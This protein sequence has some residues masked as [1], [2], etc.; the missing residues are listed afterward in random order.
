V[1]RARVVVTGASGFLGRRVVR[2]LSRDYDALAV[3]RGGGDSVPGVT[4][5]H[6]DLSAGWT[7][8]LPER[9][10][11]VIWL[12]QSRRYREFPGGAG[13]MFSVNVA[14]LF[15]ALE[16]AR[17]SGV[18]RFLYASTGSV[19]APADGPLAED[20][21]VAA[22]TFYA[23]T[24][25]SGEQLARQYAGFFEI[26]IGRVFGMYGPGQT[27]MAMARIIDAGA[28][29]RPVRLRGGIGM[30]LTPLYVDDAAELLARLIEVRL[31]ENPLVVN[32]AGPEATTLAAVAAA[33][34]AGSGREVELVAEP[35]E[36]A[37]LTADTRRLRALLPDLAFHEL[38]AGIAATV[39]ARGAAE[40]RK[41]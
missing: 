35:G 11:A 1:S 10:D 7:A 27:D 24:K 39:A 12:A 22:A 2:R 32:L 20:A 25:L 33:A 5:V 30:E 23:A 29:G 16:W 4:I 15:E 26:L 19:Y 38:A 6:R 13:D 31:P 36:P 28:A 17:R 21:P 34:A 41:G 18:R 3:S 37:R 8:A 40:Q 14:A 9:A